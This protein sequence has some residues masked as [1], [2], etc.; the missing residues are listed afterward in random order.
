MAPI[1]LVP[2]PRFEGL[3]FMEESRKAL[4]RL[5][6]QGRNVTGLGDFSL[7]CF[8]VGD[9]WPCAD[10]NHSSFLYRFG[11]TSFLVDAG[12]GVSSGFKRSGLSYDLLDRILL[13][14]L[15][16][17]HMG[18]LFMFLQG[19]WLEQRS[20]D[21]PLHLPGD[22]IVP[23]RTLLDTACIFEELSGFKLPMS[24]L[25]LGRTIE[26]GPVRITPHPSTHL[27]ALKRSY[28]GRYPQRFEAFTFLMETEAGRVAHSGDV[29]GVDDLL[30]LLE[31]PLDLLVCELA[32]FRPEDLYALLRTRSIRKVVFMHVGRHHWENLAST[33]QQAEA[34]LP[35]VKVEFAREG[36][37]IRLAD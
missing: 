12:D 10:R 27:E 26:A 22:G 9:G 29:G 7:T 35:G 15:H 5:S 37:V 19:L 17:D 13:T 25:E 4:G 34:A 16:C 20:R 11:N 28:Q 30:P 2:M 18:G 32:H 14:H 31:K 1:G 24:A 23:I 8:G 21:L 6:N 36:A 33:R 3:A